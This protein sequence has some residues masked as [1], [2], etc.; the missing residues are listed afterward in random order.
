MITHEVLRLEERINIGIEVGESHFREFKSAFE[1]N[2]DGRMTPRNIKAV[3]VDVG[4]TLVAF[5]N[6]D[7]GELLIG[8]ED[9]GTVTGIP[10]KDELVEAIKNAYREYVHSGNPLPQPSI[11]DIAIDGNRVVYFSVGKSTDGIHLTSNGRCLQRY[12]RENRPVPVGTILADRE[13]AISR[14]Y[15]RV[16]VDGVTAA[17][18]NVDLLTNAAE[19]IAQGFSPEKLLQYLG[20]AEYGGAGLQYRRA[21]LLLFAKDIRRWFPRCEVRIVRVR[22]TELGTGQNYNV[23]SD[24]IIVGTVPELVEEA[25]DALRPYL[26]RTRLQSSGLFRESL[27]YPEAACRE[28]LVN[29]IAHRDYSRE[30]SPVEIFVYDDRMDFRSPG[31]L[32]SKISIKQLTTLVRIHETRNVLVARTLRELGYM[33]E[34]GE[35]IPRM[36]DAMRDSELVDP[37]LASNFEHFTVTLRSESIF[38]RQDIDWLESYKEF[39]LEKNEQRVVLLGRDGHLLSTNEI[40]GVTGIVD[41][42]DFRALHEQLRR[43]GIIYNARTTPARTSGGRRRET[44]RFQVRPSREVEQFLGELIQAMKSL[45]PS[46]ALAPHQQALV[47]S[48]LSHGNP[49]KDRLTLSLQALGFVDS[50]RRFLPK[51]MAYVPE[52]ENKDQPAPTRSFG[53]VSAVKLGGYGFIKGDDGDDYFLHPSAIADGSEWTDVKVGTRLSFV[54]G[55]PPTVGR[56]DPA[57][58]VQL[59]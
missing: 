18:L 2:A 14:G 23:G 41:I 12:D 30:G 38:N 35:G 45:S 10:H 22:G 57:R 58:D 59:L 15:D 36:F 56:A 54:T 24:D 16:F 13:E 21:A 50:Q 34:M 51:A 25:W 29:A 1:R 20:L 31:G 11:G 39:D 32:L 33:R 49:Y 47:R 52:L 19:L 40:I 9:D 5:A 43:K 26:A 6:A 4:E 7:G 8:V 42:D 37:E 44:G 46:T 53:R 28:A 55:G 3:C 17:D 48:R 27:I